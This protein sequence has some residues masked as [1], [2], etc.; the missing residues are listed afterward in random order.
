M[1]KNQ[2]GEFNMTVDV[3]TQE[4]KQEWVNRL[5]MKIMIMNHNMMVRI[6]I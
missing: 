5:M 3:A 6:Y 4:E 1:S 2:P